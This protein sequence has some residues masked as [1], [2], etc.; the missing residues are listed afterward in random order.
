M[1]ALNAH[2][3]LAY[4]YPFAAVIPYASQKH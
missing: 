4:L 1:F 2:P 3:L